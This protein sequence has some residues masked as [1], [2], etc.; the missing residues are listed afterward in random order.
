MSPHHIGLACLAA[1]VVMWL[2]YAMGIQYLRGGMW[3]LLLPVAVAAAV[4]DVLLNYSLFALMTFDWPRR[5]ELT[6]SRRLNR[7]TTNTCWRG[8][9]ARW[10]AKYLLDWVAPGGQHIYPRTAI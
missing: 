8:G 9:A 7:L 1:I 4:L 3:R 6:F 10:T 5:R 2:L